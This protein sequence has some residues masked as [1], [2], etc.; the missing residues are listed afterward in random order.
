[1]LFKTFSEWIWI[2]RHS[3]FFVTRQRWFW[4]QHKV[5]TKGPQALSMQATGG[6]G[7]LLS[8]HSTG[9]S[10]VPLEPMN[11]TLFGNR[12]FADIICKVKH[13]YTDLG[14]SLNPMTDVLRRRGKF[15]HRHTQRRPQ[16]DRGRG[17]SDAAARQGLLAST[18]C[19]EGAWN[20]PHWSLQ[21]EP[22]RLTPWLQSSSPQS[23]KNKFL[24]FSARKLEVLC[25]N[26]PGKLI[27]PPTM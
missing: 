21:K 15:G 20:V 27:H 22:T 13:G 25:Y 3:R 2:S 5:S 7:I 4:Q 10:G 6:P 23:W 8:P 16:E 9:S 18:T 12:V 17:G 24:L 19:W 1:M 11:V 26:S 14:W